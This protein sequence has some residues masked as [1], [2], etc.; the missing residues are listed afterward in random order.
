MLAPNGVALR[1]VVSGVSD[2]WLEDDEKDES[3]QGER[4]VRDHIIIL[5]DK[6]SPSSQ[7]G[8]SG[9][10]VIRTDSGQCI[11]V[12]RGA[13]KD[14]RTVACV[15]GSAQFNGLKQDSPAYL[16][17]VPCSCLGTVCAS[18]KDIPPCK[19]DIP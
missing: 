1:G 11:A 3:K 12:L 5:L 9:S 13:T 19:C 8:Y 15:S 7:Q 10:V 17:F 2:C 6:A 14:G 18:L 16:E 4:L